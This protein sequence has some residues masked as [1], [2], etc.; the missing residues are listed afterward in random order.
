MSIFQSDADLSRLLGRLDFHTKSDR[1]KHQGE[2]EHDDREASP[3]L[4]VADF[5]GN[6]EVNWHDLRDLGSRLLSPDDDD[7]HPLYDLDADGNLDLQDL[8]RA[9]STYGE[10]VPKLDQ[11]IAQ[12]TQATMKYYG[13]NGLQTAIANG[14]IPFSQEFAGHGIHYYNQSLGSEVSNDSKLDLNHPL[15]LNFDDQGNLVAVFYVRIPQS[16][17][18]SPNDPLA[19]LSVDP[20]DNFPPESF[21]TVSEKD[22]H[23]H[24]SV[25]FDGLGSL[26]SRSFYFEEGLPLEIVASRLQQT[27]VFPKSDK[28]YVPKF[29]ML[30]GW[31]HSLNPEGVFGNIHPNVSPY[32]PEEPGAH[33][34]HHHG[35]ELTTGSDLADQIA[36]DSERN[37][38]NSFGGNDPVT[39]GQGDDLIWGSYGDDQLWGDDGSATD[40]SKGGDDMIYGGPGEDYL[41]GQAGNDKL[42]GGMGDDQIWGNEGDDLLRGGPGNDILTGD[43]LGDVNGSDLFVLAPGEG[44]DR[45]TD[46]ELGV[47]TLVLTG[48]ITPDALSIKPIASD[49]WI[50][51]GSKI[52]PLAILE[53]VNATDLMAHQDVFVVG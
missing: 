24:Q 28:A 50:G 46:F 1:D 33:G 31:F 12:A 11:Q 19:G 8:F 35:S 41:Y 6:G 38:I 45:I 39:G 52:V 26:D 14:Y 7:Y 15:G 22:W 3:L 40:S 49:T 47:D 48:G 43:K 17:E 37:L 32:A 21:D 23:N 18:P 13:P 16:Q 29:W 53:G 30:H 42:F 27:P 9:A 4:S 34:I 2:H 36:G 20:T 25:W 10:D 44:Y 5:D 51:F